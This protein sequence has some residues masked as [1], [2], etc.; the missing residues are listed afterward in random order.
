MSSLGLVV[1][2]LAGVSGWSLG[3][4]HRLTSAEDRT[5]ARAVALTF[6]A[7]AVVLALLAWLLQR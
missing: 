2:S 1:M 4:S 6:S 7:S 5:L 3:I